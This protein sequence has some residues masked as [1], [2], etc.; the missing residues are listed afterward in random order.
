MRTTR[1]LEV[2]APTRY[3]VP[4]RTMAKLDVLILDNPGG[5][6][7]DLVEHAVITR[8]ATCL[9]LDAS[10]LLGSTVNIRPGEFRVRRDAAEWQVSTSTSVWYHR[11]GSPNVD[12]FDTDEAQ[13]VR[14]E[15]PHILIGG[16]VSCGVRWVDEPHR[17]ARAER[18]LY[19]LGTASRLQ[20]RIPRSLVTNDLT[21]ATR[22]CN[23]LRLI[24]KPLS[25]G[26]G[27]VPHVSEVAHDDLSNVN[28]LPV[29]LQ[30]LVVSAVADLRVVVIGNQ[31]WTWRRI[32]EADTIDWRAVDPSGLDFEHVAY[33]SIKQD[34]VDL[35]L[36]LGLT[37]C[38]QDWLDTPEGPVFLEAN[39]AGAWAFLRGS[40]DVIPPALADHLCE[41]PRTELTAGHWARPHKR[42]LWDLGRAGKAPSNDGTRAPVYAAPPWASLA[43][44]SPEALS[45]VRRAND[46]SIAAAR[47]AEDKA[48]RLLRTALTT[49]AVSAALTGYQLQFALEHSLWLLTL[50]AP[51]AGAFASL[52]IAAFEAT[53]IDRVGFYRHAKGQDLAQPGP[54]ESVVTVV[55]EEEAGRRLALWTSKK[56]H[57]DLMQARAWFSRGL[58][59]LLLAALVAAT[60]WGINAAES[61]SDEAASHR[62]MSQ[63]ADTS[64]ASVPSR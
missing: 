47:T 16:L 15:T 62:Q 29:L 44:R 60:S 2:R 53:Q 39:P 50:V 59:L 40:Q 54:R 28:A 5:R 26:A 24:A 25:P 7:A 1:V 45:V 42:I 63:T 49:V 52:A 8:G 57:T 31:A 21:E 36:A 58:S 6:H 51:V 12:G 20:I 41:R 19:Q 22:L 61:R 4:P 34:A 30:E 48:A 13:L 37:T 32:R 23:D 27:I 35:C 64:Q 18:K 10:G 3:Q 33:Q 55:E 46:E 14:D 9:R 11:L 43:A 17:V 38:V 56:K